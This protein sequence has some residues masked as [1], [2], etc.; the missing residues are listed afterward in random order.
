MK[1]L[2]LSH[3]LAGYLGAGLFAAMLMNAAIP[4]LNW[5]GMAYIAATWPSQ[6]YCARTERQCPEP[7]EWAFS[8]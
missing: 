8:F 5:K 4:A 6:I 3:A 1:F 2:I 7:P